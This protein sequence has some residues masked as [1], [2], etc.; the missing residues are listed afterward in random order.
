MMNVRLVHVDLSKHSHPMPELAPSAEVESSLTLN[1]LLESKLCAGKQAYGNVG[2]ADGSETTRKHF[3]EPR[4][5]EF[6]T[7]LRGP[8]RDEL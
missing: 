5:Y 7:D 1:L 3:G 4:G 2:L 8:G 6:V